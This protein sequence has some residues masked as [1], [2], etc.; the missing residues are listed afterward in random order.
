M[1]YTNERELIFIR[2]N[3]HRFKILSTI[4]TGICLKHNNKISHLLK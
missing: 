1:T 4:F 3:N 2:L